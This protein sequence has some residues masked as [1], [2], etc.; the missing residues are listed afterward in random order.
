MYP[1]PI[2]FNPMGQ[3]QQNVLPPQQ[4]LQANGKASIDALRMSPN[5]S[6]LI[7]DSTLPIIWKC[8]SDSLGNVSATAYDVSLHKDE[9]IV[10]KENIN[11]SIATITERLDRLEK[12]Y[13]SITSRGAK[14]TVPTVQTANAN[15]A[16]YEKSTSVP[17]TDG[18]YQS[19]T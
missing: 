9:Q 12:N 10:E 8:V 19:A 17:V 4:I 14:P 3:T 18:K 16:R 1:Y 11:N 5:S 13:E 2:N 15:N 7:A 6:A